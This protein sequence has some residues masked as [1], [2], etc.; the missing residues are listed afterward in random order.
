MIKHL[1]RVAN[2]S[3]RESAKRGN[4][5]AGLLTGEGRR[6]PKW[7]HL[8]KEF[9]KENP[10]CKACGSS[11]RMNVHHIK[12]FHLHSDLELDK[13]NLIGLCMSKL[14]CHILIGHGDNFRAYNPNVVS[15]A[16]NARNDPLLRDG[17]VLN[18]KATR[19]FE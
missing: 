17:I 9:L 11:E 7:P 10:F 12:P 19:L 1:I 13:T 4:L 2:N 14:E 3:I 6:S 16:D 18:A 5:I 15:D 8:E